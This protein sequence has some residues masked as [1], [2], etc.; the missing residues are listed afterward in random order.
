MTSIARNGGVSVP[1][2]VQLMA[3]G[4][5]FSPS[6]S[7]VASS[8]AR[9]GGSAPG[10]S[11]VGPVDGAAGADRPGGGR[12]AAVAGPARRPRRTTPSRGPSPRG[13][14]VLGASRLHLAP[15]HAAGE[16]ARHG[17]G[18]G[19]QGCA[20]ASRPRPA[21]R[22]CRRRASSAVAARTAARISCSR[23]TP[24]ARMLVA[25]G[26]GGGAG[27]GHLRLVFRE[28]GR[29]L[30]VDLAGLQPWPRRCASRAP[31]RA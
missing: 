26:A 7:L 21:R 27:L 14:G 5:S 11:R 13:R 23:L 15:E 31:R 3:A 24:S 10:A 28:R 18:L 1:K 22:A 29:G 25:L 8:A 9:A 6:C 4:G 19:A 20:G 2:S 30:L 12:A 17:A 16:V